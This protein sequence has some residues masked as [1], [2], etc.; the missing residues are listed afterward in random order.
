MTAPM[1]TERNK[2]EA[3]YF[4]SCLFMSGELML[5]KM[6]IELWYSTCIITSLR[7]SLLFLLYSRVSVLICKSRYCVQ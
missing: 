4:K 6:V 1:F 3:L 5:L 2:D 7:L